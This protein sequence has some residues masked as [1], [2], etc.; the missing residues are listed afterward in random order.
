MYNPNTRIRVV[1]K[2]QNT[3]DPDAPPAQPVELG[4]VFVERK[5]LRASQIGPDEEQ[6]YRSV[7]K[8]VARST[9]VYRE[10]KTQD[11]LKSPFGRRR[12]GS[13]PF[14]GT[15]LPQL[16]INGIQVEEGD[17]VEDLN[18]N[19]DYRV[20]GITESDDRRFVNLFCE[21]ITT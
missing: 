11:D 7:V 15:G 12:F 17:F 6:V 10:E 14:G 13:E 8:Y 21:R 19:K 18:R 2:P 9:V 1:R 3:S 20:E 16:R 5:D 4:I